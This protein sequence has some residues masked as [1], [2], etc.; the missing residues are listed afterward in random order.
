MDV[1]MPDA[2]GY[3]ATRTLSNDPQTSHIPIVILSSKDQVTDKLWGLRQGAMSYLTKP[4]EE[5]EL[6]ETV[7]HLLDSQAG[8]IA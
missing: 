5:K 8:A 6:V 7:T 4:V 1:I 2:N 3:Q